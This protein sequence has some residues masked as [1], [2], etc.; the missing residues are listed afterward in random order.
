MKHYMAD[1]AYVFDNARL[2]AEW[3]WEENEKSGLDPTKLTLGSGKKVNWVCSKGHKWV[4]SIVNRTGK[5]LTVHTVPTKEYCLDIMI[6]NH[7]VQ[8]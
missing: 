3:D 8:I 7:N 2:M 6:Y 4:A 5:V 1:K